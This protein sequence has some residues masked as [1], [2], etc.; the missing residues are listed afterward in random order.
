MA[1][2]V[3]LKVGERPAVIPLSVGESHKEG[4][5]VNCTLVLDALERN[6]SVHVDERSLSRI[7]SQRLS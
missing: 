7:Q 2:A 3:E 6:I 5:V 1:P 4:L